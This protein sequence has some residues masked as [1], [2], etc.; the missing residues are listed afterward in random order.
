MPELNPQLT[1]VLAQL[2]ALDHEITPR[3][4]LCGLLKHRHNRAARTVAALGVDLPPARPPAPTPAW[5]ELSPEAFRAL[6]QATREAADT[7]T[8]PEHLLLALITTTPQLRTLFTTLGI[9]ES[10]LRRTLGAMLVG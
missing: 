9:D 8:A 2:A 7:P 10:D 6:A 1:E 3:D 5:P 4:L